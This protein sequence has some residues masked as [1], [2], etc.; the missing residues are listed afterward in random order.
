MAPGKPGSDLITVYLF[1]LFIHSLNVGKLRYAILV[2]HKNSFPYKNK[3]LIKTNR[4]IKSITNKSDKT[5]KLNFK[6]KKMNKTNF[7]CC[8]KILL[9]KQKTL[10]KETNPIKKLFEQSARARC[11]FPHL[12]CSFE[13]PQTVQISQ[14]IQ[15]KFPN[16]RAQKF[17]TPCTINNCSY[18][19]NV[20]LGPLS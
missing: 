6:T 8:K 13:F 20:K 18:R 10:L 2:Y 17:N 19:K 14:F 5:N 15:Y 11:G 12:Y 1:F 9:I 16:L 3:M 4:A 7:Q